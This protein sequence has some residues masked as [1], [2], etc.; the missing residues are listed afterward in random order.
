MSTKVIA[1]TM[2]RAVASVWGR[3]Q[4][5]DDG[6]FAVP[7]WVLL[8]DWTVDRAFWMEVSAILWNQHKYGV[9]GA[10]EYLD[11]EAEITQKQLEYLDDFRS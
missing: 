9:A 4:I 11:D 1:K 8:I 2:E 6:E 5:C 7:Q 10:L 3:T